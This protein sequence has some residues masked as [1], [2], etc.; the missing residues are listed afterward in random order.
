MVAAERHALGDRLPPF[1]GMTLAVPVVDLDVLVTVVHATGPALLTAVYYA[2]R[3][4]LVVPPLASLALLAPSFS[5]PP[6]GGSSSSSSGGGS[7]QPSITSI[8]N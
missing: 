3:D 4:S 2:F 7:G 5:R 6:G 8:R 1:E